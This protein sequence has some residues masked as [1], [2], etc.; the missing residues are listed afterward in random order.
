VTQRSF[1]GMWTGA[2]FRAPASPR[3]REWSVTAPKMS[4]ALPW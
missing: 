1:V 3:R 2:L 4:T